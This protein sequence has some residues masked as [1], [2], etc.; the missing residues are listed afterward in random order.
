[1]SKKL[2]ESEKVYTLRQMERQEN[3]EGREGEES[4]EEKGGGT[5]KME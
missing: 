3:P 4:G 5:E 2:G 1:M